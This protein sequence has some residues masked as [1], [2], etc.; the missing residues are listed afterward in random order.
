MTGII[1]RNLLLA[2]LIEDQRHLLGPLEPLLQVEQRFSLEDSGRSITHVYFPETAVASVSMTGGAGMKVEMDVTGLEG[3]TACH[4]FTVTTDLSWIRSSRSRVAC[5]AFQRSTSASHLANGPSC[6]QWM[7]ADR[8]VRHP[9]L[10]AERRGGAL[11]RIDHSR[12]GNQCRKT[13]RAFRSGGTGRD[14]LANL[15]RHDRDYLVGERRAAG[16][17]AQSARVWQ[18]AH[19]LWL[20]AG[21]GKGG[22]NLR[23]RWCARLHSTDCWNLVAR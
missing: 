3:M 7:R 5:S 1:N 13:W 4:F 8:P 9:P 23:S 12:T 22:G 20:D 14:R 16:Y 10:G 21:Y 18:Q 17:N 6:C 11:N 2:H 19:S 15:Q